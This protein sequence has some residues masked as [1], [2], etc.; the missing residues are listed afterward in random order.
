MKRAVWVIQ[1]KIANEIV[2]HCVGGIVYLDN[3]KAHD[4]C[5]E[6]NFP[7][8]HDNSIYIVSYL[9]TIETDEL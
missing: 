9:G 4:K 6:L 1:E 3:D 2:D 7:R 8:L 5:E